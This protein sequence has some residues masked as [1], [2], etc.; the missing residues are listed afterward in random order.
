MDPERLQERAVSISELYD[1]YNVAEAV[2][3][4]PQAI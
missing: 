3:R 4:G 2:A 1:R